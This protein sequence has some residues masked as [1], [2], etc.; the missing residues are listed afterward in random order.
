MS[1]KQDQ[2]PASDEH[3]EGH[4]KAYERIKSKKTLEEIL[5]VAI[6]FEKA[7]RDFYRGLIPLVSKNIRYVVEE[8]AVEEQEHY[9]LFKQLAE[10]PELEGQLQDEIKT[11]VEDHRFSDYVQLPDLGPTPDDQAILQYAMGREDAAMKQYRELAESTALGPAR[12]LFKF[13]ANE[14]TKHK[15]ELE[16]T[17][18]ETVYRR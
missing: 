4:S 6:T 2:T 11:P 10:N 3:L 5:A 9:E 17:Y 13:L 15:R 16:K 1:N 7:A 18:Y 14:E 12:D 8:L